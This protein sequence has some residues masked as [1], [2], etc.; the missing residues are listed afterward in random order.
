MRRL[1]VLAARELFPRKSW[2]HGAS[3]VGRRVPAVL[4]V[5]VPLLVLAGCA[6]Q[7]GLVSQA[8]YLALLPEDAE[9]YLRFPV[10]ENLAFAHQLVS[11][12]APQM[13]EKDIQKLTKRFSAVY[14]AVTGDGFSA[15]A[16]GSFPR[17]GLSLALK[18]KNGWKKVRDQDIPVTQEYYQYQDLPLQVAFPSSSV[19]MVS[20]R[21]DSLLASYQEQEGLEAPP[22]EN[23]LA[24]FTPDYEERAAAG[25]PAAGTGSAA[26]GESIDFYVSDVVSVVLPIL[27]TG[28]PISLPVDGL[29][30]R[31][32]PL[33]GELDGHGG[34]LYSFAGYLVLSDPR[35][36]K[37]TLT[38][39]RLVSRG[40]GLGVEYSS[41]G[42]SVVK[43]SGVT[44]SE[45]D[46]GAL[47]GKALR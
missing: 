3:G 33:D 16:T 1:D 43:L 20:P 47:L 5:L 42:E 28:L 14:G 30:G 13:D 46:L 6:S 19:M 25:S 26:V 11:S 24:S 34:R 8:D 45:S 4:A 38:A 35:A 9:I 39:L 7:R 12:F 15:V 41:L 32:L 18:E 17:L 21:V 36:M 40:L 44:V 23:P 37:P 2:G 31:F 10:Q 29:Y 22:Y 27:G